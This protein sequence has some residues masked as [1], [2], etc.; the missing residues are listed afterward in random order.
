[1]RLVAEHALSASDFIWPIFIIEGDNRRVA[2]D[3]MPGVDRLTIDL[4]VGAAEQAARLGIPAVALFPYTDQSLR[5][6]SGREALNPKNLVCRLLLEKKNTTPD[7]GDMCEVALDPYTSHGHD[8]F[9][10]SE[11][12]V[13]DDV[14]DMLVSHTML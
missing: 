12:N 8:S 4:A 13:N 11:E 14:I 5:D 1:R 10:R 7:I 9:V 2:V 3:T 6:E